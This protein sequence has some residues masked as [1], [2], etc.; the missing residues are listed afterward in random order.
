MGTKFKIGEEEIDI[1]RGINIPKK[2]E[3]LLIKR[4]G[5]SKTYIVDSV[6]HTID[7]DMSIALS[8]TLINL[9][10]LKDIDEEETI[11]GPAT[12]KA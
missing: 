8:K 11:S 6:T 2:D 3:I 4:K 10:E 1:Q 7:Y 12:F 5:E 9:E